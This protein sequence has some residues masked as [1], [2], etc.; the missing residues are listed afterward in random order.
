[1]F[2]HEN[3]KFNVSISA[4]NDIEFETILTEIALKGTNENEIVK[5]DFE[6]RLIN[7]NDSFPMRSGYSGI[8]EIVLE[9]AENVLVIEEKNVIF[10]NDSAFVELLIE[11][12]LEE[13]NIT[14]GI[15]DGIIVEVKSGLSKEDKIKAR[16]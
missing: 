12:K 5:F 9:K 14:L 16:N 1:M 10:R 11:N 2:L 15:S 6:G 13:K 7:K 8:A 3:M 4:L